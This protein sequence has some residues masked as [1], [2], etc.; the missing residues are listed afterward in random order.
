M[1]RKGRDREKR[2]E[3]D[4]GGGGGGGGGAGVKTF[5]VL[6]KEMARPVFQNI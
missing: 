6:K 3:R 4:R 2:E 1:E 5:R